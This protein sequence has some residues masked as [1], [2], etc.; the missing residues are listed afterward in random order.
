LLDQFQALNVCFQQTRR[1]GSPKKV[2]HSFN[3][4]SKITKTR[5]WAGI[6][7]PCYKFSQRLGQGDG[8]TGE[9]FQWL[10]ADEVDDRNARLIV[11]VTDRWGNARISSCFY[12]RVL[13][14]ITQGAPVCLK[15]EQVRPIANFNSI[16][17]CARCSS[18]NA[19]H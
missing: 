7:E 19:S 2:K 3:E 17:Q 16:G 13:M 6:L 12:T 11:R 15:P 5:E 4:N 14:G 10:R 1:E 18:L 9:V 8:A